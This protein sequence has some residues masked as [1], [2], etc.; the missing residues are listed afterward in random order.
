M[1]GGLCLLPVLALA[2]GRKAPVGLRWLLYG[3]SIPWVVAVLATEQLDQG[4]VLLAPLAVVWLP[5]SLI[6]V[7]ALIR[8]SNR[9]ACRT[10]RRSSP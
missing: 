7:E 8:A 5:V 9:A 1:L 10:N 6:G 4:L 3:V 2:L